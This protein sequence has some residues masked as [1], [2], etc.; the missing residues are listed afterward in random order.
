MNTQAIDFGAIV[1]KK[2]TNTR[3]IL[4]RHGETD[5]NKEKRFQGHTDIALNA[6]GTQQAQLIR[7]YFDE[8]KANGLSLYQKCVCS[9]LDRA[10]TTA[11][12]ICGEKTLPA[13]LHSGL[14]ERHYGH[15]AGLTA[16]QMSEKSPDEFAA[17][18][19]R[20][21]EAPL[22]G[23]E[24]LRQFYDRVVSTFLEI[25]NANRGASTLLVAHGGVLDCIYRYCTDEPLEKQRD[26]QLPNCA[27]NI[28]ELD[29]EA[30]G[31]VLLWAW[32][33]HLNKDLPGQNMDE[34]DG[35]VT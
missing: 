9:D 33:G 21:P 31:N 27:L 14:R 29:S 26:W 20:H 15:L 34:V 2:F 4:V 7:K 11:Q 10:R 8:L 28:V 32:Q 35:R 30:H 13:Q 6:H 19:N 12:I 24:S 1:S 5:W 16:N 23:G 3:F 25:A 17:L 18:S 22:Q